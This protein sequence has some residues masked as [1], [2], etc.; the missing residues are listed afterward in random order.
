MAG[1]LGLGPTKYRV[2]S[3]TDVNGCPGDTASGSVLLSYRNSPIATISGTDSICPGQ[4]TNLTVTLTSGIPPWSYSYMRDGQY[5]GTI[6]VP[7]NYTHILQV[8]QPGVYTLSE[9]TDPSGTGCGTGQAS[10]FALTPPTATISGTD[11]ICEHT[12]G[13]LSVALTGTAPWKFSYTRNLADSTTVQNVIAS[14]RICARYES[15]NLQ[16]L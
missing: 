16:T 12:T 7:T 8:S 10:I 1:I 9:V 6:N 5:V 13:Y 14:P 4:P 15:R 11:T 3:I 2:F